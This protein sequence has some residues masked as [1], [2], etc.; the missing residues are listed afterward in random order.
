MERHD[1]RVEE[2]RGEL[3]TRMSEN[4]IERKSNEQTKR[5]KEGSV[6]VSSLTNC[7]REDRE[8]RNFIREKKNVKTL[9]LCGKKILRQIAMTNLYFM[10]LKQ[11]T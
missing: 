4:L 9:F 11:K 1:K 6:W 2:E 3:S 5:Q 10:E 8:K 7:L